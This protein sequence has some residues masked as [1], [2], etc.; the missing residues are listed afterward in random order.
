MDKEVEHKS[1]RKVIG[2]ILAAGTA[3]VWVPVVF[4][5]YIIDWIIGVEDYETLAKHTEPK[6]K[7]TEL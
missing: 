7:N 4:M 3:I 6:E 5:M 2:W 1:P